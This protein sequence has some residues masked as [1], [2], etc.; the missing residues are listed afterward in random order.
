MNTYITKYK[1]FVLATACDNEGTAKDKMRSHVCHGTSEPPPLFNEIACI[2]LPKGILSQLILAEY[3]QTEE[4]GYWGEGHPIFEMAAHIDRLQYAANAVAQDY[5]CAIDN[6][7]FED[8]A[9][10]SRQLL[11]C[12]VEAIVNA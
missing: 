4:D 3:K 7:E 11:Q 12:L 2:R 6:M 9:E 5:A 10:E 8:E 1:D